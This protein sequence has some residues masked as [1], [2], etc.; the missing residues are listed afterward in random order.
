MASGEDRRPHL[1][2]TVE[3][4]KAANDAAL[5]ADPA[6]SDADPT[7]PLFQFFALRTIERER[8][9]FEAGDRMALLAAIRKCA[10]HDL[11]LPAWVAKAYIKAYD[12]V[13]TCRAKSWDDATVFGK[14]YPKHAHLNALRKKRNL[15]LAVWLAVRRIL[16]SEPNTRIDRSLFERVGANLRPPIGH[17][18]AAEFYYQAVRDKDRSLR[19]SGAMELLAPFVVGEPKRRRG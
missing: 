15:P 19:E 12:R 6:R 3:Q 17:S 8:A 16:D 14:P 2:W 18:D 13:L 7:L 11:V 9:R 5:A 10:N 1:D 4:A